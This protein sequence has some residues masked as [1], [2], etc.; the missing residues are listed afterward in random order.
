MRRSRFLAYLRNRRGTTSVELV[1]TLPFF[2]S[3]VFMIAET[4]IYFFAT[5]NAE[6]AAHAYSRE[7]INMQT[8]I[9]TAT[10]EDRI[11]A[12]LEARMNRQFF[13]S[14]RFAI[15]TA[16]PNTDFSKTLAQ[17]FVGANIFQNRDRPVFLR[18]V[19][20]PRGISSTLTRPIWRAIGATGASGLAAPIDILIVIPFPA[21]DT[22]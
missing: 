1:L 18:V 8:G 15:D 4:S 3:S 14:M 22:T 6:K 13:E 19:F 17:N 12:A 9:D 7:I 21:R 11:W 20:Q 5:S 2:F 16:G 10:H